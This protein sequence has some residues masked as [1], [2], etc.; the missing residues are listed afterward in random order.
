MPSI[1][2]KPFD[3][4]INSGLQS[5]VSVVFSPLIQRNIFVFVS[6]RLRGQSAISGIKQTRTCR[7][8]LKFKSE[9]RHGSFS[10][11]PPDEP[12]GET[13][14]TSAGEKVVACSNSERASDGALTDQVFTT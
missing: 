14:E 5:L 6:K 13:I 11:S 12:L 8:P 3:A 7:N 9:I 2:F 4:S 1:Q 10:F